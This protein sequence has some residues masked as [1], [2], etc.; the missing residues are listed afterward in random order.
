MKIVK[1]A[2]RLIVFILIATLAAGCA[3]TGKNPQDPFEG[4]NRTMFDFNDKIDSAVMKPV[5][6]TYARVT[7]EF[8][9]TGV[10]NF[11]GNIN[12]VPTALNNFMQARPGNG[13]SDV[14]RVLVNSTIGLAGLFDVATPIG[15]AKHDQDFGQTLGRWGV[16]SGPYVIL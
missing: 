15:L 12:D 9:Q 6:Q 11:F 2:L 10:G 1:Q 4:Y 5:A 16:Q 14:A 7:P 8:V 3:S 13:A